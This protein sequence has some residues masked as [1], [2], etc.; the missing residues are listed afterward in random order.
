MSWVLVLF[1]LG[2]FAIILYSL[3]VALRFLR[4]PLE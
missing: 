4:E 3:Y 2:V 1:G